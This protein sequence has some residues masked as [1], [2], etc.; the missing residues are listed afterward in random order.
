MNTAI[1]LMA[2]IAAGVG[3]VALRSYLRL[4]DAESRVRDNLRRALD[5]L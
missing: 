4:K 3:L 1:A 2:L 5:G